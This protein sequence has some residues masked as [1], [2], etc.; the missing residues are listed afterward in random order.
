M[1]DAT[2]VVTKESWEKMPD[3][4]KNWLMFNTI[5]SMDKRI[6]KLERGGL[7]N[8]TLSFTGGV[9]GGIIFWVGTK[10]LGR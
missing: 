4:E 3:D 2:M 6:V 1:S 5:Q 9:V 7:V 8:K 10:V